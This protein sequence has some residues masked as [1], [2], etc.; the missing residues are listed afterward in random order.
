MQIYNFYLFNRHGNCLFYREWQRSRAGTDSQQEQQ[1]LVG[2]LFAI[3]QLCVS[4]APVNDDSLPRGTRA[5]HMPLGP[6][7][8]R[9]YTTAKYQL[10]YFES[11]TGL[12]FVLTTSPNAGDLTRLLQRI[13]KEAYVECAVRNPMYRL[14]SA[15]VS[16]TFRKRVD[17]VVRSLAVETNVLRPAPDGQGGSARSSTKSL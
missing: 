12:R 5:R 9:N 17:S 8:F 10:H 3:K 2:L 13:Y 11:S 14:G 4:V 15:I 1:N 7:N 16:D 6:S